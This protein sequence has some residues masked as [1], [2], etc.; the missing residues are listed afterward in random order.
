[1]EG[2]GRQIS[3]KEKQTNK[4]ANKQQNKTKTCRSIIYPTCNMCWPKS[5][6]EIVEV[7]NQ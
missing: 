7:A 5:Q 3:K 1:V 2:L 4:H 6:A